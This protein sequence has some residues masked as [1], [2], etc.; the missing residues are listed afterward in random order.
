MP[1]NLQKATATAIY[2][3]LL[4]YARGYWRVFIAAFVGMA[5]YAATDATFAALLKPLL[6]KGFIEHDEEFTRFIPIAILGLI[7]IRG[8][9]ALTQDYCMN[10]IGRHVIKKLRREVFDY[11]LIMP[12]RVYDRSSGGVL[13]S[14]LTFNIEQVAVATTQAVQ[15]LIKDSLTIIALVSWMFYLNARFAALVIVLGPIMGI[16]IQVVSKIF[17]RYGARIQSSMGDLTRVAEEVIAGHRVVKVFNAQDFERRHFEEVNEKNRRLHMRMVLTRA[18]GTPVVQ[19]IAAGAIAGVIYLATTSAATDEVSVGT[20]VSFVGAM[21]FSMSPLKRI[22][23]INQPLQQG[24]AAGKSIFDMIDGP[25]EPGGGSRPL[26]KARG[27]VEFNDV[28]FAYDSAIGTV[29]ADI[30]VAVPAG[31]KLAIVGKSGS[32]KSTL[33]SLLPR[34]YDPTSGTILIDGYDISQYP[35]LELRNQISLVSQDIVLFNDTIANNIAYGALEDSTRADIEKAARV[36]HVLEFAEKLPDGLD[37]F[38]GD[39]GVLLSG[40]Q[41]QRIA[42]A[43]AV[44]KNSPILILDEATSALDTESERHIQQALDELMRDRT[45]FI[46]AHRLSTV[47][48]ADKI[49]VLDEGRAVEFGTHNDLLQLDGHYAGLYRLQFNA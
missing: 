28:G 16:L 15:V 42:I 33:V 7:T 26:D 32:G 41:R 29:L 18:A 44:L 45:T 13:L 4:T 21:V 35:L 14:K 34:F 22:T 9:A 1:A 17:R 47:E 37:A 8:F 49:L 36:A 48:N 20:F 2:R 40:G 10:W 11:F 38:V 25:Q 39:R 6:D 12:A 24:I 30:S 27:D 19:L 3:R 5:I 31:E 46:I 43:R 23:N